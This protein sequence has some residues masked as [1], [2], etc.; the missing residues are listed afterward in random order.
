[1]WLLVSVILSRVFYYVGVLRSLDPYSVLNCR[2]TYPRYNREGSNFRS[3]R[4][5]GSG[6]GPY[7]SKIILAYTNAFHEQPLTLYC[8]IW[9]CLCWLK[10]TIDESCIKKAVIK[11]Y[12]TAVGM[13]WKRYSFSSVRGVWRALFPVCTTVDI[14]FQPKFIFRRENTCMSAILPI[15]SNPKYNQFK[16]GN[17]RFLRLSKYVN[18][19]RL[20]INI[21]SYD[22]YTTYWS[23]QMIFTIFDW[24]TKENSSSTC[25]S[26]SIVNY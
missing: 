15:I 16:F 2:Y 25:A 18:A 4:G 17:Q 14:P 11:W 8:C 9:M 10:I 13:V 26:S 20:V 21:F 7:N 6:D 1:M 12:I 24:L 23:L 3:E 5:I 19:Y 22:R